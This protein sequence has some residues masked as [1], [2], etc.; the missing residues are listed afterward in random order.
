[1]REEKREVGGGEGNSLVDRETS[2]LA[3]PLPA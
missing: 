3:L 2:L 1:M